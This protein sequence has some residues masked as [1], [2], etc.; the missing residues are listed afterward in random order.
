MLL[1]RSLLLPFSRAAAVPAGRLSRFR[2]GGRPAMRS[3]ISCGPLSEPGCKLRRDPADARPRKLA[4]FGK[5]PVAL[6]SPACRSRQSSDLPALGLA[7]E[8]IRRAG[9]VCGCGGFGRRD[10]SSARARRYRVFSVHLAHYRA[11]VPRRCHA[12]LSAPVIT[13]PANCR[14]CRSFAS[15]LACHATIFACSC[16]ALSSSARSSP[17]ALALRRS[18]SNSPSA[19]VSTSALTAFL[20]SLP[21]VS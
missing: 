21:S 16:A 4:P 18:F 13:N 10:A 8:S 9:R 17:S 11:L 2:G 15:K 20:F 5:K 6:Q 1:G 14:Y 19:R 3:R 7:N 12:V